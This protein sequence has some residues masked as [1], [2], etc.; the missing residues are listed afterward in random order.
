MPLY[1]ADS[2]IWG[3]ASNR[4]RPDIADK[5]AVRIERNEIMTC[6]PVALEILNRAASGKE[7]EDLY[8]VLLEPLRWIDLT[9]EAGWRALGVQRTLATNQDFN[10]RRPAV[11]YLMAA[12]AEQAEA[13]ALL[14]FFDKDMRIICDETGQ[15][16]EEEVAS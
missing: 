6:A 7:Y 9:R 11:D 3:W 2:S 15:P 14:W 16:C 5:L 10:H 12:I 8:S 4:T 1:L 13:E